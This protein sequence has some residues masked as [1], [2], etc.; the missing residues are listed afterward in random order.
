VVRHTG[1]CKP[2]PTPRFPI[3]AGVCSS[4]GPLESETIESYCLSLALQEPAQMQRSHEA[5]RPFCAM[6]D[7]PTRAARYNSC[8]TPENFVRNGQRCRASHVRPYA[9]RYTPN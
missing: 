6:Q 9:L 1:T 5:L 3:R 7:L 8:V 4:L 2:I